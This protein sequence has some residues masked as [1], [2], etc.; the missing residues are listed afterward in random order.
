MS[1]AYCKKKAA[2]SLFFVIKIVN[3]R[4]EFVWYQIIYGTIIRRCGGGP[5]NGRKR[6]YILSVGRITRGIHER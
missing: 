4:I 5:E 6:V 1:S 2:R 3:V